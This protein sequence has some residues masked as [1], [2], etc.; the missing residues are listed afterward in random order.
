[1]DVDFARIREGFGGV[2]PSRF[3][4]LEMLGFGGEP[5]H[6]LWLV[7]GGC[8]CFLV[9][10]INVVNADEKA[11]TFLFVRGQYLNVN[12]DRLY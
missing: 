9:R 4:G 10:F 1:M 3:G 5:S 2:L 7:E 8:E 11:L 12:T 6:L